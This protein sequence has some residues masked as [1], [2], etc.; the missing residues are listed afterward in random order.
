MKPLRVALIGIAHDHACPN[1]GSVLKHPEVFDVAGYYVPPTEAEDYASRMSLFHGLREMTMA[2]ILA[3]SSIEGLIVETY[4]LELTHYAL[5]GANAGKHIFMDK[6]GGADLSAFT[7][8]L[9]T[10]QKNDLVLEIGY[11]YRYNPYVQELL[12]KVRSGAL[13]QIINVEAQMNCCHTAEKRQWLAGFPGGMMFFLGCHLVDLVL[14]I[15]GIPRKV[16]PMNRSSGKDG[17]TACD[18]G[19]ALLEYENGVSFVKT[20]AAEMG[21]FARRQLVVV[22]TKGT[23]EINPLEILVPGGQQTQVTDYTSDAWADAGVMRRS[24]IFNR[25]DEMMATFAK[26]VRGE[27]E[28]ALSYDYE[29]T[30]YKVLLSCCGM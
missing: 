4:E 3:D 11:M 17:V 7:Q 29:L 20:N 24:D 28:K 10:I 30:L 21:G 26:I 15:Q 12:R 19:F 27:A 13:G 25:Y 1:H 18:F 9:E 16:L 2:E 22:G 14:Q 5:L 8:L 6:P 23:V